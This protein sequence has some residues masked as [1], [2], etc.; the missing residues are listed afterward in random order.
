[1]FVVTG[2]T[3]NVG[4]ELT[5][6]LVDRPDAPAHRIAA[7][8]PD[9]IRARHGADVPVVRFDY[10]DRRT[11]PAV[12]D[13]ITTLFLLFP[14]PSPAAVRT[15]MKPFV[16]AAAAAGC[17]HIVYVSVPGSDRLRFLPHYQVER[18][19]EASGAAPT[20]LRCSYFGQNL[21]RRISTHGVDIVERGEVFVPAGNGRTTFL[22]AR[23][24]AE[25]ALLAVQ[26]PDE[27]RGTAHTLTGPDRLDLDEVAAIL[28]EVLDRPIRYARPSL[29]Q[30]WDRLR[31]RGV[32]WDTLLFMTIVYT[33]TRTG[34]NEPVTDELPHLLGRPART[35]RA[36]A[37]DYRER[38]FTRD[39]T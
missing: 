6:L 10:D 1:V 26:K 27:F 33:L 16:D 15:R 23:D 31:R 20:F 25:V 24:V 39:W 38:W 7:H 19:I 13:G 34:R 37:E 18:H 8:D 21:V 11:W 4:A 32:T 35:F 3:G 14:L 22:D 5:T 28:S 36:F 30:F 29:P 9:R 12:L 2:P 17:G